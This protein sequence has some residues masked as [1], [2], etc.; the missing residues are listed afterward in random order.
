MRL[1]VS[2]GYRPNAFNQSGLLFTQVPSSIL[3]RGLPGNSPLFAFF[4]LSF[5]L[6]VVRFVVLF[7][8]QRRCVCVRAF[9]HS[10]ACSPDE[11][12]LAGLDVL[13]VSC[14]C[15]PSSMRCTAGTCVER[16]DLAVRTKWSRSLRST[17]TAS[18]SS[19]ALRR[20]RL[21][22]DQC[23]RGEILTTLLSLHV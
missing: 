10:C 23:S 11:Q 9:V 16:G 17:V 1:H 22:H 18:A 21:L 8:R 20:E 7:T 2:R 14:F 19:L 4:A 15:F 5:V 6:A 12:M 13:P 3:P